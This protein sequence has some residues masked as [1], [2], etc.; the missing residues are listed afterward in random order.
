MILYKVRTWSYR[1]GSH[2]KDTRFYYAV[3][4]Q[5]ACNSLRFTSNQPRAG[6]PLAFE[7]GKRGN[8]FSMK[9]SQRGNNRCNCHDGPV[10]YTGPDSA[11]M[12]WRGLP[13]SDVQLFGH[14]NPCCAMRDSS[15][16]EVDSGLG[17]WVG[18]SLETRT[19]ATLAIRAEGKGNVLNRGDGASSP[20]SGVRKSKR[21]LI[22]L[23]TRRSGRA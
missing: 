7:Y 2:N 22:R 16:L 19:G 11:I 18:G 14:R 8:L 6:N 21:E 15:L 5:G 17:T 9:T 4:M 3:V 13:G 20:G 12:P 23:C 10:G 1:K